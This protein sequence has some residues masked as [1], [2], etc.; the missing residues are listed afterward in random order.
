MVFSYGPGKNSTMPKNCNGKN[1]KQPLA[2]AEFENAAL[3]KLENSYIGLM[4]KTIE[5]AISIRL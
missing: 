3:P 1:L 5:P 4:G 2:A